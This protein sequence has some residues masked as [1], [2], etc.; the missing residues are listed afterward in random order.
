MH[1]FGAYLVAALAASGELASALPQKMN[2]VQPRHH[3]ARTLSVPVHHKAA[4][5]RSTRSHPALSYAKALRKYNATLPSHVQGV[6]D[7]FATLSSLAKRAGVEQGSVAAESVMEDVEYVATI[8]IG[9]PAQT[10]PMDFDTGSSDLWVMGAGA[11][12]VSGHSTYDSS[13][14]STAKELSG[15]S[16]DISYGD[17]SSSSGTVY[18]DTVTIGNLTFADQAVE[19]AT[20]ISTEFIQDTAI[21]G[22]VGLAMSSINT[23]TPTAQQT[24]FDNIKASLA[25]PLFTADLKHDAKGSYNFGFIDDSAHTGDIFYSDLVTGN[26]FGGFWTF[27]ASGYTVGDS[28]STNTGSASGSSGTSSPASTTT[29]AVSSSPTGSSGSGS[30]SGSG[31]SG[32]HHGGGDSDGSVPEYGSSSSSDESE[33][34][35]EVE[36]EIESILQALGLEKRNAAGTPTTA[37]KQSVTRADTAITGIAD[38]GTT[39]LMLPEAVVTAYYDQVDGAEMSQQ[40]GGYVFSCDATLPDFSFNVGEGSISVPGTYINFEPV[41][42]GSSTCYGGIQSD[43]GIGMAIFGDVALKAALVVF[44]SGNNRLGWAAKATS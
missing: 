35:A 10:V 15:A 3:E 12:G 11:S 6:V 44:D 2:V 29:A 41:S 26:T 1:T 30:D 39:L 37:Q 21:S 4:H 40:E 36:A 14:S 28:T 34:E 16:W 33:A 32:H 20:K 24:W 8:S 38:T 43:A 19:V 42:T 22:L 7:R 25:S 18:T 17:G 5:R 23:V 13:S 27:V 9:T 31:S